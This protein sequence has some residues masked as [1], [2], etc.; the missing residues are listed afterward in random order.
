[1]IDR[2]RVV[3]GPALNGARS[4]EKQT[5]DTPPSYVDRLTTIKV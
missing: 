4:S 2:V 5:T 3:A 1:M